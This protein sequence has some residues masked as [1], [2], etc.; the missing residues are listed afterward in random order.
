MMV[1]GWWLLHST[2]CSYYRVKYFLE[3]NMK[4]GD[5]AKQTGCSI[6]TIRYYEREGL[7]AAP[8]RSEGNFRLYT[9]QHAERLVFIR[10]CRALDM[11]H[12]EIRALLRVKDQNG[13]DCGDVNALLDAHIGHVAERIA[14]LQVLQT[15]LLD[16]R[17]ACGCRQAVADCGILQGLTSMQVEGRQDRY[18]HLG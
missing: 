6:E 9:D 4:I 3:S 18:T 13:Q 12:E 17:Q 2:P 7:L 11:T 15:Q 10:N 14:E 1:L 5:L 16:L 8:A